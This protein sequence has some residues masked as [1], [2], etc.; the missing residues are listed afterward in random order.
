[1]E[2]VKM[3]VNGQAMSGGDLNG[4]LA[5]GSFLGAART[6]AKYRFFS[7]RDEFP[8]LYP[9][10]PGGASVPGEL[11]EVEYRL[12]CDELLPREPME[13]ELTVIELADGS[14]SLSMRMRADRLGDEGVVDISA[15]GG[16]RAYLAT[17]GRQS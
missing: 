11:Y 5:A 2:K 14:G 1:M 9:G 13:L 3:F 16:W 7:V 10:V 6:A 4:A 8:G 15:A 17:L 12:L